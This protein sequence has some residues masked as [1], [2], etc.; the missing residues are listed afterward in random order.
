MKS[1]ATDTNNM[2]F[3]ASIS[4][5]KFRKVVVPGDKLLL[6][7][8]VINKKKT[9]WKFSCQAF[10]DNDIACNSEIMIAKG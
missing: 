4:N 7:S 9:M 6:Q 5:V 10:V 2:F 3:L 1:N 8:E